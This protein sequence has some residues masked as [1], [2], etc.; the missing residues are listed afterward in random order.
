MEIEPMH[1]TTFAGDVWTFSQSWT[2]IKSLG[3]PQ[4]IVVL[5]KG[6]IGPRAIEHAR[7]VLARLCEQDDQLRL[8]GWRDVDRVWHEG[9]MSQA[10]QIAMAKLLLLQGLCSAGDEL[11]SYPEFEALGTFSLMENNE[12]SSSSWATYMAHLKEISNV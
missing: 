10:E 1:L 8:L 4:R 6:L 11:A 3:S 5:C 7:Y 12:A 9:S 2:H